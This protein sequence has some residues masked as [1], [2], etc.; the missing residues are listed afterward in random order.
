M[1]YS[2]EGSAAVME[3]VSGRVYV[4]E[5]VRINPQLRQYWEGF[6]YEKPSDLLADF[7]ERY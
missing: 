5:D 6:V 4:W 7:Q 3:L 2:G 1:V